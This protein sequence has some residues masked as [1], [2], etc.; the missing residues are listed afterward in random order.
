MDEDPEGWCQIYQMKRNDSLTSTNSQEKL[1][2]WE[3]SKG[4]QAVRYSI[5]LG[6]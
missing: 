4:F 6:I 3:N 1:A 2:L 5:A